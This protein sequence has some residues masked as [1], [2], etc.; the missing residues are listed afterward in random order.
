MTCSTG[1]TVW[2]GLIS[3]SNVVVKGF[4]NLI[5]IKSTSMNDPGSVLWVATLTCELINV[6]F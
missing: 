2:V 3:I 5:I 1:I 6:G 4:V